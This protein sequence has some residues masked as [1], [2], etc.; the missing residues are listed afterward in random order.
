MPPQTILDSH[1]HLWP[2]E[3]ANPAGHAWMT[4]S[5]M[6]LAKPHLL[7]HYRQASSAS[8]VEVEG[9]VYVETDVRYEI[10]NG[11]V[12]D[13]AKGPLDEIGFLRNTIERHYDA[14]DVNLLVGLVPWAPIDQPTSVLEEYLTLAEEIAGPQ[15]WQRIK[16]FRFLLQSILD[17]L[18]FEQLVLSNN[19]VANLKLLGRRGFS[20]DVGVDQHRA[21]TWQMELMHRAIVMARDGVPEAEQVILIVNHL[22]KPDFESVSRQTSSSLNGKF[23]EWCKAMDALASD[24]RTYMKLSGQFSEIPAGLGRPDEVAKTIKPWVQYVIARFGA[25]R[26]MFG[27]DWPVCNVNGPAGEKSW[28]VWKDVVKTLLSDPDL[29]LSDVDREWVWRKTASTAYCIGSPC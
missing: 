14:R 2:R 20:F 15:T 8:D 5:D 23:E 27:S 4:P 28:V 25:Q 3:T 9:V 19:F 18:A 24:S 7:D 16:G 1:I 10:P 26:V 11:K 6:P 22:C 17:Q 13:W 29:A 12:S 21:G